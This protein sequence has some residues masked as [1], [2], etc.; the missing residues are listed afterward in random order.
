MIFVALA[1]SYSFMAFSLFIVGATSAGRW[2]VSY[3]YLCEFWTDK[4]IKSFG[5]TVNAS[6]AVVLF[7][8]AFILQFCT[9]NTNVLLYTGIIMTLASIIMCY[10]ML[11]ESP[12]W[13]IG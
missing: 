2:T 4:N 6:A 11:P 8:G 5:P 10:S 13:L 9:K 12:K 7:L 3:I 1:R